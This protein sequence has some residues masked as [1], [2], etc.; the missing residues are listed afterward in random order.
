MVVEPSVKLS[1]LILIR[2]NLTLFLQY[3]CLKSYYELMLVTFN[4]FY[5]CK[6][7]GKIKSSVRIAV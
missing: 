3:H 1:C 6:M 7:S 5:F 4:T 2:R